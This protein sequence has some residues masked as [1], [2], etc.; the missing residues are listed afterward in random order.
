[1]KPLI[2]LRLKFAPMS[3]HPLILQRNIFYTLR[4]LLRF[5]LS[6]SDRISKITKEPA[7]IIG[8][9]NIGQIKP[10]LYPH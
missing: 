4:Q 7:D 1:V 8:I 5:W 3:D 2:D 10:G 9:D 6:K